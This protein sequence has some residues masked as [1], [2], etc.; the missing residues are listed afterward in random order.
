MY[1]AF[2]LRDDV[3][4]DMGQAS[5]STCHG[6]VHQSDGWQYNIAAD[7]VTVPVATSSGSTDE[8]HGCIRPR[9]QHQLTA[10]VFL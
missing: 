4:E 6:H 3:Y 9:T 5:V 1:F 2:R 8:W 7:Y 10:Y